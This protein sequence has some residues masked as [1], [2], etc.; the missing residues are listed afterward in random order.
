MT[1][2]TKSAAYVVCGPPAG[3]EGTK[4]GPKPEPW[5]KMMTDIKL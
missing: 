1:S 2:A 3:P 4:P 5:T